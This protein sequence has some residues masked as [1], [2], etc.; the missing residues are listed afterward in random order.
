VKARAALERLNSRWY[1]ELPI[2]VPQTPPCKAF[3]YQHDDASSEM[4]RHSSGEPERKVTSEC[5]TGLI[6]VCSL[7]KYVAENK[8]ALSH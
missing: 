4:G 1:H 7:G 5:D 6:A 2:L 8:R 3:P